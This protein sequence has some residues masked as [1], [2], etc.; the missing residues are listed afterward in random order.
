MSLDIRSQYPAT[1]EDAW[2]KPNIDWEAGV[3]QEFNET[4]FA[5]SL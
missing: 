4:C 5:K 1:A 2:K 3:F